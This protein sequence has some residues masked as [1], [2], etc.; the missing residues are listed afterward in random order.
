[1]TRPEARLDAEDLAR[2][3]RLLA[4]ADEQARLYPGPSKRHQPVHTVYVPADQVGRGLTAEWGAAALTSLDEHAPDPAALAAVVGLDTDLVRLLWPR[5]LATLHDHPIQDLRIDV[6]DGY[7]RRRDDVEDADL[8][9]AVLATGAESR[10]PGGP[11][12]WGVRVKS[13]DP[14]TRARGLRSLDLAVGAASHGGQL[15]DGFVITLP[16]VTSPAQ[17]TALAYVCERLEAVGG[18]PVGSLRLEVQ[19]ETPQAVLGPDGTA[20]VASVVHAG[21]GRVVGL[22]YGTYDYSAAL[23]ISPAQQSMDHPAA[24]HA[25]L[26]MQLAAAGT[27]VQLSD[28]STNVLPVG[29]R[30]EAHAG[31]ALHARL[32][33]RS[34]RRGFPQGWD[35]HP[36]QLVTRH[37]A[38]WAFY[39]G[40]LDAT[41]VRLAAWTRGGGGQ[42]LDEPATAAA[43]TGHLLRALDCGAVDESEVVARC[44]LDRSALL[45]LV[46]R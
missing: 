37:L 28:G 39:R 27:G 35:L 32:V 43:L 45:R 40:E 11:R 23:G 24:D 29:G 30:A 44:G 36:A 20:T 38:T 21:A 14:D 7:G 4:P 10:R 13:M 17:L 34:L 19:V 25:K 9:A 6:E 26:V 16:K 3:E 42:V 12:Q 18:L 41:C 15:P 2:V 31:W 46:A 22:H 5:L 8:V 33:T 1:M